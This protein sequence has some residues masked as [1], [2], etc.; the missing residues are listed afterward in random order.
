MIGVLLA[1]GAR[2]REDLCVVVERDPAVRGRSEALLAP[3]LPALWLHRVSHPLH[4]R[5]HRFLARLLS[6]LGRFLSGGVDIH[7]GAR[8]GRRLFIDHGAAVVIGEDAVIG[9]DVTLYHQVTIGAVGWWKDRRRKPGERRHP[10]LGDRVVVGVSASVLGPV[11][12]GD[13]CV[14][15]AHSLVTGDVPAGHSVRAAGSE[16]RGGR[17][18][19]TSVTHFPASIK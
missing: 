3:H 15:G 19:D 16:I 4:T 18:N 14:I 5:G 2:L 17:K 1:A 7:P 6:L 8:L 13:D 9:T 12:V 11:Q 10:T